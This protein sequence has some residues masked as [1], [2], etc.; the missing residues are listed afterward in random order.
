MTWS[1][2]MWGHDDPPDP[3]ADNTR[4][5]RFKKLAN[6]LQDMGSYGGGS[7]GGQTMSISLP[8]QE[9]E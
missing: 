4:A 9:V 1:L 6:E 3:K 7:Y 2:S 8:P 5:E